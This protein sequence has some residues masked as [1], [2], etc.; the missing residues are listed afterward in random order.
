MAEK[1]NHI[2]ESKKFFKTYAD[3]L[4]LDAE[5]R[6]W[7]NYMISGYLEKDRE[8]IDPPRFAAGIAYLSSIWG[9]ERKT[10]KQVSKATNIPLSSVIKNYKRVAGSMRMVMKEKPVLG[11]A[12]NTAEDEIRIIKEED[13]EKEQKEDLI[14]MSR[15]LWTK[16]TRLPTNEE[17]SLDM[18]RWERNRNYKG[19]CGGGGGG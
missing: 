6:N 15:I 2:Q 13:R 12:Y 10:Q 11:F 3:E 9:G 19:P 18:R 17:S 8:D 4:G 5:S 7:G 16:E 1:A 14:Y